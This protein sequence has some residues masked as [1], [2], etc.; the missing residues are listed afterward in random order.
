MASHPEPPLEELQWSI[1]AARLMLGPHISIQVGHA[2]FCLH[3][4][5]RSDEP[6]VS[7]IQ[8]TCMVWT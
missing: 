4:Q 1:A 6:A 5:V 2:W 7:L 3:G 8:P